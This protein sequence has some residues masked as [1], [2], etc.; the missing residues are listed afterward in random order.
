MADLTPAASASVSTP[1][2]AAAGHDHQRMVDRL[3]KLAQRGKAALAE[4]F[5]LA[6]IDQRDA[7][8]IAELAQVAV[9]LARPARALGRADDGDRLR[10]QR[11]DGLTE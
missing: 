3:G 2:T 9:N 11:A 7:P 4:H 10:L 1:G 6:R 5:F 8:G